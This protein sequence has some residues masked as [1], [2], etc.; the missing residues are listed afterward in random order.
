MA[1]GRRCWGDW[2]STSR[3]SSKEGP[4]TAKLGAASGKSEERRRER[5]AGVGELEKRFGDAVVVVPEDI[6]LVDE[7]AGDGFDVER[8]DAGEICFDRRLPF[9]SVAVQEAGRDRR[10]VDEGEVEEPGQTAGERL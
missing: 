5:I 6:P 2:S 9:A 3:R 10:G 8:A 4:C 1:G 7:A